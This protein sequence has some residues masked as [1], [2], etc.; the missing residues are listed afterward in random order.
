MDESTPYRRIQDCG[1]GLKLSG[2][3]VVRKHPSG[4][5]SRGVPKWWKNPYRGGNDRGDHSQSY[6]EEM[7]FL[8]QMHAEKLEELMPGQ[9][10][11]S[12]TTCFQTKLSDCDT[13][14]EAVTQDKVAE[15]ITADAPVGH[16]GGVI[17]QEESGPLHLV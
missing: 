6:H 13:F 3:D 16:A 1:S 10:R 12:M 8:F 17:A 7:P 9:L 14:V 4:D 2:W 11:K 15:I 5:P